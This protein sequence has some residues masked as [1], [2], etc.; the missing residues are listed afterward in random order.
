MFDTSTVDTGLEIDTEIDLDSDVDTDLEGELAADPEVGFVVDLF[1]PRQAVAGYLV[2][3]AS[4]ESQAPGDGLGG[5]L[6]SVDPADLDMHDLV[7]FM[8]ACERQASFVQATQLRAVRELAGR[9]LVP[10]PDGEPADTA[11]P[12]GAVNEYAADEVAAVLA[13]SRLTGQKRVWLATALTRLPATEAALAAGALNLSKTWAITEGLAVLDDPTAATVEAKLLVRAPHQTLG[14]LRASINR[15]VL[16]ADPSTAKE[17]AEKA[18]AERRVEL[19]PRADGMAEF[20]ALLPAPEAMALWTAVTALADQARAAERAAARDLTKANAN[21]EHGAAT[22]NPACYANPGAP[23]GSPAALAAFGF[24]P[25]GQVAD[26]RLPDGSLTSSTPRGRWGDGAP[27]FVFRTMNQLRADVLADLAYATLDRADLPR[28]HRRRPHIQVTVA[29]S[30]LLGL[31]ELPGELAGHGPIPAQMARAVAA[32]ATWRRLLTDP[33]TGGLLDYGT[34][35]Y[36]P[37]KNLADHVITR[38]QTCRGLGCRIRAERCDI[39]HTIRYPD[40][41]TAEHNLTCECRH[42]HIRKHNAGWKL[43]LL[44]NGDVIWT[45]PTGHSYYD[46][47]P[48]VL[49][50]HTQP[51]TPTDDI[52]PF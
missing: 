28:N 47:V 42:C 1:R 35:V 11:L 5:L 13:M 3:A 45:S 27:Q 10:G 31:D 26:G 16:A 33:A 49:D 4:L 18:K 14:Q 23:T 12:A 25:D 43:K 48:P 2:H 32:D 50:G 6:A 41:P 37:P 19:T 15:A 38:D 39:D 52:P 36:D 44:P 8:G 29:A 30:T 24:T 46:P 20:W 22:G 51:R 21:P 34:T 17:R 7:S 40:G 9:R